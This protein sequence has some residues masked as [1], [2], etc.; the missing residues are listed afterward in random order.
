M[1]TIEFNIELDEEYQPHFVVRPAVNGRDLI[2]IVGEEGGFKGLD[3][4]DV[5]PPSRHFFGESD[6]KY[7]ESGLVLVCNCGYT[8]CGSLSA[9]MIVADESVTWTDF[10]DPGWKPYPGIGPFKFDRNQYEQALDRA[11]KTYGELAEVQRVEDAAR[12]ETQRIEDADRAEA[13][14]LRRRRY[15]RPVRWL[16]SLF[17]Q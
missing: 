11:A 13:R 9:S 2:E 8:E 3:A 7:H 15:T 1:D 17:R 14:R 12:A 6:A 10:G 5:L 4:L 16:W